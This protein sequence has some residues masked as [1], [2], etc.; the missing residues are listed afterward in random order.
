MSP[1]F[2]NATAPL[3][4]S[5]FNSPPTSPLPTSGAFNGYFS[6]LLTSHGSRDSFSRLS[7]GSDSEEDSCN[8]CTFLVPK[9]MSSQLPEGAPGSPTK[10]GK[11]RHGSPILRTTQ[12]VVAHVPDDDEGLPY[13]HSAE[14]EDARN[15]T[16]ISQH[17]QDSS[18]EDDI[19]DPLLESSPSAHTNSTESTRSYSS[20]GGSHTHHLQYVTTRQPSSPSAYSLLRRSCIRTLSCESLPR[21]SQSGPLYFGDPVAGYTIAYI[22]RL[23]DPRARGRRRM[24]ALLALGG[25]DSWRVSTAMVMITKAFENIAGQIVAMADL[26]LGKESAASAASHSPRPSTSGIVTPLSTSLPSP[27][28]TGSPT[29]PEQERAKSATTSPIVS[30]RSQFSDVSSFLSARKVD[31]DGYPRVSRDVMRAK[32]LAE[33]VGND[34]F[35]VELHAR[36]CVILAALVKEFASR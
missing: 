25:K 21:G 9:N 8:N 29:S 32:G 19:I 16:D 5:P 18:D 3:L 6:A 13:T 33:I 24:Y 23:P 31:P 10:D 15:G 7:M 14:E 17:Q 22:F 27:V 2:S 35:F 1:G 28:R 34:N 30:S 26:V 20:H 11:G 4:Y 12:A 36:F